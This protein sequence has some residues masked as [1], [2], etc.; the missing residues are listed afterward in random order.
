VSKIAKKNQ[1][2]GVR[3]LLI[4]HS[5]YSDVVKNTLLQTTA[6]LPTGW[7]LEQMSKQ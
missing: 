1:S 6:I 4:Q 7:V 3:F 5:K 2:E